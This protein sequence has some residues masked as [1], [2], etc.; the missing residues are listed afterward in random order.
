MRTVAGARYE[1]KSGT[2]IQADFDPIN[3]WATVCRLT[4]VSSSFP[5]SED[6]ARWLWLAVHCA[7]PKPPGRGIPFQGAS[8][9]SL[10]NSMG[11]LSRIELRI[12]GWAPTSKNLIAPRRFSLLPCEVE[13][14]NIGEFLGPKTCHLPTHS[15][16]SVRSKSSKYA[17]KMETRPNMHN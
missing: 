17:R 8:Q 5:S 10:R 4:S 3:T 12:E 6:R 11:H 14:A 13:I 2:L 7:T 15:S 9:I 1:K 16:P